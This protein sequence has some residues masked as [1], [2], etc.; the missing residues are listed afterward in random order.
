MLRSIFL[1]ISLFIVV[2]SL[3]SYDIKNC[4]EINHLH[5]LF[6][7]ENLTVHASILKSGTVFLILKWLR[8]SVEVY[9]RVQIPILPLGKSLEMKSVSLYHP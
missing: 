7:N 8:C 5:P 9:C 2:S 3:Q 6:V 4:N 1:I